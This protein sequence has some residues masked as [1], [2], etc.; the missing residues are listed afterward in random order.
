MNTVQERLRLLRLELGKQAGKK[1]KTTGEPMALT[2]EEFSSNLMCGRSAIHSIETGRND[3]SEYIANDICNVY[4]VNY[5]W[6]M[7]GED[8]PMFV[9]E[10]DDQTMLDRVAEEYGLGKNERLLLEFYLNNP[11][12][13]EALV[14]EIK[15]LGIRLENEDKGEL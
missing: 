12:K 7:D 1:K 4:H 9:E 3:L 6:L 5:Q 13:R 2:Q 10:N 11:D 14:R 8:V 15:A